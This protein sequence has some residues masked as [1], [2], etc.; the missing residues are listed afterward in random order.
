M[1]FYIV[2]SM[3]IVGKLNAKTFVFQKRFGVKLSSAFTIQKLQDILAL[4]KQWKSFS[5]DSI[6]PILLNLIYLRLKSV[7]LAYN[8][9]SS[10]KIFENTVTASFVLNILSWRITSN[11]SSRFNTSTAPSLCFNSNWR[12][13]KVIIRC[14][15]NECAWT[16]IYIFPT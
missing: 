7:L 4:P 5:R 12:F 1:L 13:F 6:S 2:H 3:T 8:L 11:W 10:I 9:T 15:I 16:N 14:S